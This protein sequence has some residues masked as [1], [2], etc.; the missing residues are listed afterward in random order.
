MLVFMLVVAAVV[1]VTGAG[2]MFERD[3]FFFFAS[4]DY[5]KQDPRSKTH[6]VDAYFEQYCCNEK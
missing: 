6:V 3:D 4:C 5:K 1:V 2:E